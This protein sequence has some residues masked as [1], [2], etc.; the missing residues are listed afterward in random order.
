[1]ELIGL[2]LLD[3][4]HF[5]VDLLWGDVEE[6]LDAVEPHG[7]DVDEVLKTLQLA[8]IGEDATTDL[9]QWM[10]AYPKHVPELSS[11]GR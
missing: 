3:A 2:D 10:K 6:A 7:G 8:A 4:I 9:V 11:A 1:M 5:A